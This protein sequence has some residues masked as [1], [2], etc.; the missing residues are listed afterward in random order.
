MVLAKVDALANENRLV[1]SYRTV[2][3]A[4]FLTHCFCIAVLS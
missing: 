4:R 1:V 3:I 2:K